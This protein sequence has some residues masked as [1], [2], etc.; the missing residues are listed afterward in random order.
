MK[1]LLTLFVLFFGL[2]MANA[3]KSQIFDYL[4]HHLYNNEGIHTAYYS[5]I[6]EYKQTSTC[7]CEDFLTTAKADFEKYLVS[8]YRLKP[9]QGG[10]Y[11]YTYLPVE[12]N[13]NA[14]YNNWYEGEQGRKKA[15]YV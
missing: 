1:K 12:D 13:D 5:N 3:Q 15:K 14:G 4:E 11:G 7:T 8:Q 6:V 2:G 10:D 9:M